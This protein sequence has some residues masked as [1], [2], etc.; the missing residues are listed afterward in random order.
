MR[1]RNP[2][3][4]ADAISV[5]TRQQAGLD[6]TSVELPGN[7]RLESSESALSNHEPNAPVEQ[8][9]HAI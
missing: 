5:S 1:G 7:Q 4:I 9:R 2:S 8:P 6:R 3:G